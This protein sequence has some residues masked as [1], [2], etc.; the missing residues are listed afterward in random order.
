MRTHK[1][2]H[3]REAPPVMKGIR[4]MANELARAWLGD[5]RVK[6]RSKLRFGNAGKRTEAQ[7]KAVQ[8]FM[9]AVMKSIQPNTVVAF[10]DGASRGNPGPAGAGAALYE[11][12]IDG[13]PIKMRVGIGRSTNNKGELM[14]IAM[15]IEGAMTK[16][17]N[18][19]LQGREMVIL[20]DSVYSHGIIKHHWRSSSNK[21]IIKLIRSLMDEISKE[22][23]VKVS[24][25]W[26]PGHAGLTGNELAD[27]LANEGADLSAA[28]NFSSIGDVLVRG[29][30][31]P[32]F[33]G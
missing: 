19:K 30:V 11:G 18:E 17:G 9:D 3:M 14:A 21:G 27:Q 16:I 26:I 29:R 20:T 12:D 31:D 28:D 2:A 13:D 1:F 25:I 4:I 10:T 5:R 22:H 6:D 24:T 23:G 33:G 32:V 7:V 15:A 8:R